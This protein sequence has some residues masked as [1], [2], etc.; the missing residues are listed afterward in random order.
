MNQQVTN[1][2]VEIIGFSERERILFGSIFRLSQLRTHRYTEAQQPT[3]DCL[4]LDGNLDGFAQI[5]AERLN[6][7]PNVLVLVV[8]DSG[9]PRDMP[10]AT[11]NRPIRWAG[12]LLALDNQVR[13]QQNQNVVGEEEPIE[14]VAGN[15]LEMTSISDW[16]DKQ[17][18][19]VFQTAPAVLVV[20][21]EET[22]F[23]YMTAKLAGQLYRVDH[24]K[25]VESALDHLSI[26]RY[27]VVITQD[28]L[29]D[30]PGIE[31]CRLI[32]KRQDRRR[33]AP[34]SVG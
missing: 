3:S 29:P 31:L 5:L 28:K 34:Y 1:H 23:L 30:R 2:S 9:A 22:T 25:D 4:I 12:L 21:S 24:A 15:D 14:D 17:Q 8:F 18:P 11:I 26:N 6:T 27:N 19:V 33:I 20:D 32:K 13:L 7:Q 10:C 16:Y